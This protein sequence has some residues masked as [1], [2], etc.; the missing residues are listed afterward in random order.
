M[1]RDPG[2]PQAMAHAFTSRG[3]PL[4]F[5]ILDALEA[6]EG[7]GG[8]IRGRQSAAVR[9]VAEKPDGRIGGRLVD[10]RV[11]DHADPLVELRR[12][13]D[14]HSAGAP[15]SADGPDQ[16]ANLGRGNPEGWFWR[17]VSLAN[18]GKEEDARAA[19]R[20]AFAVSEDWRTLFWRITTLL[21]RDPELLE[22]LAR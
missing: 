18:E 22:R 15:W 2:V 11:D 21:P 20:R 4:L 7:A 14:L 17:G 16:L 5:R 12:L 13:A 9:V 1:M 19:F 8:D 6:A 10:L 3:G